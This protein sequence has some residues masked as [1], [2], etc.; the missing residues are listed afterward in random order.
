MNLNSLF[1][2]AKDENNI[3]NEL[4]Q[5]YGVKKGLRNEDGTGVLIGL[6]RIADVVGYQR[7]ENNNKID[8][9]GQLY[10]RDYEINDLIKIL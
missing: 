3:P 9:Y 5:K 1:N 4:Y 6:T 2:K 10:Y 7:D 8:I